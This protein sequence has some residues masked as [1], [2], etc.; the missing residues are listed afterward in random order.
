MQ[1]PQNLV[2]LRNNMGSEPIQSEY[3]KPVGYHGA[4]LKPQNYVLLRSNQ[5]QNEVPQIQYQPTYS[6]EQVLIG[7]LLPQA[8]NIKQQ[9]ISQTPIH[10]THYVPVEVVP[11]QVPLQTAQYH[12]DNQAIQQ[13]NLHQHLSFIYIPVDSNIQPPQYIKPLVQLPIKSKSELSPLPLQNHQQSIPSSNPFIYLSSEAQKSDSIHSPFSGLLQQQ[14]HQPQQNIHQEQ[15]NSGHEQQEVNDVAALEIARYIA[16]RHG[17]LYSDTVVID[18]KSND[19]SKE[20]DSGEGIVKQIKYYNIQV[21]K[22]T[23]CFISL[24]RNT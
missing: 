3:I 23:K 16:S 4:N 6:R 22:Y 5:P 8:H 2:L 17:D 21:H 18:A 12:F 10:Q 14:E 9:Q 13:E 7:R 11:P 24:R 15:Q 19:E 1:S 20:Q